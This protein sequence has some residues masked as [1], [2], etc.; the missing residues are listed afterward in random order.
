MFQF[1]TIS[2]GGIVSE[3]KKI[4]GL[5]RIVEIVEKRYGPKVF[6][7]REI[8]DKL[9]QFMMDD[10][11]HAVEFHTADQFSFRDRIVISYIPNED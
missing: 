1:L 8:A 10:D 2:P 5:D 4:D 9:N 3:P 11:K 6:S 7:D